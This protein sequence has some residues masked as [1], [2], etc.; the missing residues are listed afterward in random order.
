[1]KKTSFLIV[2]LMFS[3]FNQAYGQWTDQFTFY[4]KGSTTAKKTFKLWLPN[5]SESIVG[6]VITDGVSHDT[7][8]ATDGVVRQACSDKKFGVLQIIGS[9]YG[10]FGREY[11]SPYTTTDKLGNG[12]ATFEEE[13]LGCLDSLARRNGHPEIKY[14]PFLSFGHSTSGIFARSIAWWN[15]SRALGVI[16]YKSGKFLK[17]KWAADDADLKNVP[18]LFFPGEYEQASPNHGGCVTNKGVESMEVQW[19][20]N[21]DSTVSWNA[22]GYLL[23]VV[24]QPIDP[25][26]GY[27]P[28][29]C[30]TT[31]TSWSGCGT[32]KPE[33]NMHTIWAGSDPYRGMEARFLLA[34]FIT[35][36]ADARIPA[37]T[38]PTNGFMTLKS[39][40]K[41]KGVFATSTEIRTSFI[42]PDLSQSPKLFYYYDESPV[43]PDSSFYF[44]DH[45]FA[46]DW[47]YY[48]NNYGAYNGANKGYVPVVS[49]PIFELTSATTLAIKSPSVGSKIYYTTDGSTPSKS[50]T[51]YTNEINFFNPAN[52]VVKAI[53]YKT[54][55]KY[56]FE[57][58]P[59]TVKS[60]TIVDGTASIKTVNTEESFSVSPN[61]CADILAVKSNKIIAETVYIY[62][63]TG[64]LVKSLTNS[65]R[66]KELNIVVSDL[67]H[68]LY[69]LYV[70]DAK[71]KFIKK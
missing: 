54:D 47:L 52:F 45:E 41:K 35:K 59:S 65:S 29:D 43:N 33:C 28:S 21:R 34:S 15:P 25:L 67:T 64:Q 70:G 53:A 7:N 38:Y 13:F 11:E 57:W 68:G 17:P 20:G 42:D 48:M 27:T 56:N 36:V 46:L 37:N 12:Y 66:T 69:I 40:D 32:S 10:T 22:R 61:P 44:L 3:F 71:A 51:L 8:F 58:R 50:S 63:Q 62:T 60:V 26:L 6:L 4:E 31:N 39:I 14:A 5:G 30:Y 16:I 18:V 2:F 49:N 55:P 1:M 9:H 23:N 24:A 19:Q